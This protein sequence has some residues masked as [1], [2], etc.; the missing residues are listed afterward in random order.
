MWQVKGTA[1]GRQM[2]DARTLFFKILLASTN[3]IY[4]LWDFFSPSK[5]NPPLKSYRG[6]C[7]KVCWWAWMWSQRFQSQ[8]HLSDCYMTVP[9]NLLSLSFH[10]SKLGVSNSFLTAIIRGLHEVARVA[11]L[12]SIWHIVDALW[13]L[14]SNQHAPLSLTFLI[15]MI[16]SGSCEDQMCVTEKVW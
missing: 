1:H 3:F 6:K 5:R 7:R 8:P 11:A 13:V 9:L 12:D 15:F 14:I 16:T 4:P 2:E 10:T